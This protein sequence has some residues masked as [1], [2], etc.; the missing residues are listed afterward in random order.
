M[1]PNTYR[2]CTNCT[3]PHYE[4]C[5]SCWGFG[6]YKISDNPSEAF[7]VTAWEVFE[8]KFKAKVLPCPECGS[9]ENGCP[10]E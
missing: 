4:N 6:V 9:T 7:A 2:V 10:K 8:K 5:G 3:I 1:N